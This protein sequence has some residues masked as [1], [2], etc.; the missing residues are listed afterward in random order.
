M[1][2]FSNKEGKLK[3]LGK[4]KIRLKISNLGKD[5]KSEITLLFILLLYFTSPTFEN[6]AI[7]RYIHTILRKIDISLK[8]IGNS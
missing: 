3:V 7:L 4:K 6:K 5:M 2:Q 1:L 8:K